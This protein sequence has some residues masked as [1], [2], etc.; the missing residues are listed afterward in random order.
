LPP[1]GGARTITSRKLAQHDGRAHRLALD[2]LNPRFCFYSCGE[3][4]EVCD[5]AAALKAKAA[6]GV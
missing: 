1:G 4:G 3:D 5:R 2:P 6:W